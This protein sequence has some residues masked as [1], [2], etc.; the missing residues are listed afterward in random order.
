M[1]TLAPFK[2]HA[3]ACWS[4]ACSSNVLHMITTLNSREILLGMEWNQNVLYITNVFSQK[5]SIQS[6]NFQILNKISSDTWNWSS[7]YKNPEN[8][9]LGLQ[10]D[11]NVLIRCFR[12]KSSLVNKIE[13]QV[14][15]KNWKVRG[16]VSDVG[17]VPK[18]IL[19]K[20]VL[21]KVSDSSTNNV[22]T[23]ICLNTFYFVFRLK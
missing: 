14:I 15:K 10:Q 12:A 6:N 18:V 11:L 2:I 17:H 4:R 16:Y 13:W 22:T 9:Y 1:G 20:L 19:V 8:N 21:D 7:S 5:V 23:H 3:T